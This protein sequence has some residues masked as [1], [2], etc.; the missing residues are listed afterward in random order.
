MLRKLLPKDNRDIDALP[1][2]QRLTDEQFAPLIPDLLEYYRDYDKKQ[3]VAQYISDLLAERRA[4]VLPEVEKIM[5]GE[6][7]EWQMSIHIHLV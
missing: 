4:M 3:P 7:E 2:L 1:D 6:D 5:A